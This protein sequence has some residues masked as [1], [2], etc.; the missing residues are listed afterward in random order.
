MNGWGRKLFSAFF[1]YIIPIQ[2]GNSPLKDDITWATNILVYVDVH[3]VMLFYS[4]LS[5]NIDENTHLR[6]SEDGKQPVRVDWGYTMLIYL[7]N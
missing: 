3:P 4:L 6:W 2:Q 7:K 1:F 5:S